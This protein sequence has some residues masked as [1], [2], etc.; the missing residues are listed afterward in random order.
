MIKSWFERLQ[1][2]FN[3]VTF[4]EAGEPETACKYLE[5]HPSPLPRNRSDSVSLAPAARRVTAH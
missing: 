5:Q 1:N 2:L 3:A 4:A